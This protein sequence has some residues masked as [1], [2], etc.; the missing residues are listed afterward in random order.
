VSTVF[1]T[2]LAWLAVVMLLLGSGGCKKSVEGETQ[3]WKTNTE[4]VR[5]LTATYPGFKPALEARL[6]KATEIH[7]AATTLDGD[8][9]IE[10]LSEANS[11]LMS[12][13]VRDLQGLEESM[14][15]LRTKR[16]EA[17]AQAG[18][19]STRLGAKVAA[20]DAQKALDRAQKA[21][22]TGAKDEAS[23]TAVV[24][25]VKSDIETAAKAVESVLKADKSKKDEKAAQDEAKDA[26][27]A[28]AKAEADAKVAPWTC[29][30][31]KT[32]NPHDATSCTS[33]GAPKSVA[34]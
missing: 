8:A 12:G 2:L 23:A 10:K 31:C 3:A 25:S 6:V 9:K 14:K 28:A 15:T 34:K 26:K 13:W 4:Q 5:G 24:K 27:E 22:E 19:E 21:L 1:R 11:A 17:A 18:D 7:D 33:C 16:V 30:Y 29:E 32:E 20:E